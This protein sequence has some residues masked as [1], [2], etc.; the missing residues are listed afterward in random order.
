MLKQGYLASNTVYV[1]TEHTQNI[2]D[3]YFDKLDPIVQLIGECEN[4]RD[5]HDLL[6]GPICHSGFKRLN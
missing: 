5:I 6:D 3:S 1:C 2:L 4:G